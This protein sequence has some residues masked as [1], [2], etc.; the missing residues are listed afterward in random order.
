MARAETLSDHK[1]GGAK[2][3]TP[4]SLSSILIQQSLAAKDARARNSASVE[5]RETVGC[6]FANQVIG[7]LP[8]NTK[9]PKIDFLAIGSPTQSASL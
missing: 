9:I 2:R 4:K 1:I 5:E 8:R 6:Y 7:E 3:K